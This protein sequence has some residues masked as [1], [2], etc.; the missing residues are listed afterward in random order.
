MLLHGLRNVRVCPLGLV[1]YGVLPCFPKY[2]DLGTENVM[3]FS[4]IITECNIKFP[5]THGFT[6]NMI[7]LLV[8]LWTS[9]EPQ[10]NEFINM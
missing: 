1:I 4:A 3:V 8:R 10:L 2:H 5:Y 7:T 6:G 9:F